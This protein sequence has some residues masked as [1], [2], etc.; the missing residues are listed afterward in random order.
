MQHQFARDLTHNDLQT[1]MPHVKASGDMLIS[2]EH[3]K[4]E[5]KNADPA[6]NGTVETRLA[7]RR[8]PKGDRLTVSRRYITERKAKELYPVHYQ[9]YVDTG[10]VPTV[11]T[12]LEDLP[13]ISRS[14]INLLV[15]NGVRSIEDV[16]SVGPDR[17]GGLGYSATKAYQVAKRWDDQ[18]KENAEL[19]T[20][21]DVEAKFEA[22]SANLLKRAEGA[23]S[24]AKNLEHQLA[25]LQS[26]KGM[27]VTA[28]Q[29]VQAM[30]DESAE[31]ETDISK[32][33]NV[34]GEGE[35]IID[36]SEALSDD[37]DFSLPNP[38]S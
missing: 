17:L 1:V 10:E 7:I 36:A 29:P 4:V 34:W 2:F 33:P 12:P 21:A 3:V 37:D 15:I 27:D 20:M 14:Q 26:M 28:D 38:L 30:N 35:D 32:M 11:G 22:M 24:H 19:I 18:R 13:G 6:K 31:L 5:V 25:A 16:L 9:A 23:E 8:Q